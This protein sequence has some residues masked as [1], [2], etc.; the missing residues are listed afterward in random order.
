MGRPSSFTQ[1]IAAEICDLIAEGSNLHRICSQDAYP[2]RQTIFN[3]LKTFPDFFDNYARARELR[4]DR[5]SE[6]IDQY[7]DEVRAGKL[8]PQAAR[9]IID[10]EKWQAGKENPKIYGDHTILEHSGPSGSAIKVNIIDVP[11]KPE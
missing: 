7:I 5:R 10:A 11:G 4:A 9:V 8:D 6:R 2:N 1:E 3:W